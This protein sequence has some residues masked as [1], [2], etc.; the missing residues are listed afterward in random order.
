MTAMLAIYKREFRAFMHNM[1]GPVFIFFLLLFTGACVTIYNLII[2]YSSFQFAIEWTGLAFIVVIPIITMRSLS[3]DKT[4]RTNQLLFTLPIKISDIVLGKFLAIA[5]VF[6]IPV[7]IMLVYPVILSAYG[8]MYYAASYSAILA[9]FLL[10]LALISICMF[11]SSFT[12]SQVISAIISFGVIILLLVLSMIIALLPSGALFSFICLVLIAAAAALV[13]WRLTSNANVG[14]ITA[15]LLVIPQ[16]VVYMVNS[17]LYE[18]LFAK[19]LGWISLYE[20]FYSLLSGVFDLQ[21]V[22]YLLSVSVFFLFL[23]VRSLDKR[24][25]S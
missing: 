22:V 12:E 16:C 11:I 13:V 6:A 3:E 24:R 8:Y 7:A 20:R 1:T 15:A 9:L 23:S 19:I 18:G 21:S 5:T 4:N 10:G 14:M 17:S 25:W 2:G